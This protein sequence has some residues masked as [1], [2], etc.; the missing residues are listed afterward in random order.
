MVWVLLIFGFWQFGPPMPTPRYGFGVGVVGE[1]IYVI[2]G[3]NDTK[4]LDMIEAYNTITSS[5][6]SIPVK[7]PTPRCYMGCATY[8]GKIYIIGGMTTLSGHNTSLVERFDPATNLW[9]TVAPLPRAKSGLVACTYANKIYAVGGYI[10]DSV[11]YYTKT[12]ERYDP[13]LNSWREVDSLNTPRINAGVT[14]YNGKIY[15]L[16]GSYYN[17]LKSVEYY[18][19]NQWWNAQPMPRA[20][21]GFGALS[22]G[23]CIY[24]IAG[25]DDGTLLNSVDIWLAESLWCKGPPLNHPRAYFGIAAVGDTIY[26]IGGK[27]TSGAINSL[28]YHSL[29]LPGITEPESPGC[30]SSPSFSTIVRNGS[31][32]SVEDAEIEVYNSI[33]G[34]VKKG[35]NSIRIDFPKGVYFI[36]IKQNLNPPI[37]RKMIVIK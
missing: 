31:M 36:R 26:V 7:L 30:P 24:A 9:D 33:G 3:R 27:G 34:L 6:E 4:I 17:S 29:P 25:D 20:R 10:R 22:Y 8:E 18:V 37:I 21:T 23:D 13:V 32:I 2:G 28:E 19:P 14:V 15:A 1:K 16:G 35:R 5:W 11:G 12:V